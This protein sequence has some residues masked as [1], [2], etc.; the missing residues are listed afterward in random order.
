MTDK[1]L[2]IIKYP[3]DFLRKKTEEIKDF[4]DPELLK[5]VSDMVKTMEAEKGI[6]LAAPQVGSNLR[7]C[8]VRVDDTVYAL[9]NPKIKSYS[10]KKEIFEEGCLSFPG[11]FFPIERPVKVKIRA[12]DP[13][14]KKL[15]IKAEGLLA[16]VFQ[17]EIDHLDGILIIDRA[18]RPVK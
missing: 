11:K 5:L 3:N 10:R 14:G 13:G 2:K 1:N 17:H 8:V 4:K 15:K 18:V 9:I 12:K 6:G 7:I 16:R